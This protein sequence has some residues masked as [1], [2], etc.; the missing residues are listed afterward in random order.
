MNF[1]SVNA[2][3]SPLFHSIPCSVLEI[4]PTAS[5]FHLAVD[6]GNGVCSRPVFSVSGAVSFDVSFDYI[7]HRNR[8]PTSA[9]VTGLCM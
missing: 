7:S 5:K 4:R 1:G 2:W 6:T 8:S 3:D 9:S